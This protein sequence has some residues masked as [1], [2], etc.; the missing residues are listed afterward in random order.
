LVD[1]A[2]ASAEKDPAAYRKMHLDR[3]Q[4]RFTELMWA[5]KRKIENTIDP[6]SM[7]IIEIRF[8]RGCWGPAALVTIGIDD[9]ELFTAIIVKEE[10]PQ[11]YQDL[12]DIT[13][14]VLFLDSFRII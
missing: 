9:D 2:R 4:M 8:C 14:V 5:L 12:F 6:K 1:L 11:L 10:T 13:K 7:E 3:I